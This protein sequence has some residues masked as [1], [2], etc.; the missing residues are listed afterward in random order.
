V[1]QK[2]KILAI[3]NQKGGVGKTTTAVNLAAGLA[4]LGSKTLLV[5]ADP[6][7]NASSGVGV[8]PPQDKPT[9]F[10]VLTEEAQISHTLCATMIENLYL[11][12]SSIDL[13]GLE[14]LIANRIA[15]ELILKKAISE[16]ISEY[17]WII[18]DTPPA[19]GLL[20]LNC[21][22]AA[23]GLILPLQCEY[24]ALEGLTQLL[25]TVELV[26]HHLN[27]DLEIWKVLMTMRDS[28]TRLAE[29]V[30]AE[31]RKFFGSKVARA[32][33]PRN[34]RISESPSFGQPILTY[35]PRSKGAKA[36]FEFAKEVQEYGASRTW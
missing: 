26:R 18:L 2:S 36:Y 30:E 19:L 15:R 23:D 1:E 13:A 9:L 25:R 24:Y 35:D 10:E 34:V 32:I 17:Q 12:P 27:P 28:R 16:I 5:D 31:I 29:Q 20:T 33:I 22:S 14:L 7:G 4:M 3:V 21:L 8:I 11:I 6:Q